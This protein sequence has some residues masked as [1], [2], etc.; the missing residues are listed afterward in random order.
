MQRY[1]RLEELITPVLTDLGYD[2]VRVSMH[3]METRKVLQV[4]A[5]RKDRVSMSIED[6]SKISKDLS[7]VLDVADPISGRY[8]LEVS[9]PGLDRPLINLEDFRRFKG[10]SAKIETEVPIE[11]LKRL[12][13]KIEGVSATD[14]IEMLLLDK[15]LEVNI[16]FNN[17]TKAKLIIT[18]ELI[19][20]V[21]KGNKGF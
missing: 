12:K 19:N 4:M 17:I 6:C 20:A 7:A 15:D 14:E 18:E 10:F 2:L 9:S 11:G 8:T 3:G 5:E 21:T 1:E 13:G 16:P